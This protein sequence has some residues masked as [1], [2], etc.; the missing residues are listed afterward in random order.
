MTKETTNIGDKR[1]KN[2]KCDCI[3]TLYACFVIIAVVAIIIMVASIGSLGDTTKVMG[4]VGILA[5]FVVISN[6]AQM[7]E[8]RKKTEDDIR[9]REKEMDIMNKKINA[10]LKK[11]GVD[12]VAIMELFDYRE[13]TYE[14]FDN[15]G[16]YNFFVVRL[17]SEIK[18]VFVCVGA[19]KGQK[20]A[21]I[22]QP[23]DYLE[24]YYKNDQ[25]EMTKRKDA[26][27]SMGLPK[28]EVE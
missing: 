5:T 15:S 27:M 20:K 14:Y 10:M 4:V 22:E 8:I 11:Y 7:V 21:H 3:T 18:P 26:L 6:Y 13:L 16:L 9:S 24:K 25:D 23:K 1:N 19:S 12:E 17:N 2:K 28:S